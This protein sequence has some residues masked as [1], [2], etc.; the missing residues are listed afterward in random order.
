M[1]AIVFDRSDVPTE[2]LELREVE[3]PRPGA[4]EVLVKMLNAPI[5]PGDLLFIQSLYPDP[6][7]PSLPGQVAGNSG[8]GVVVEKGPG[9]SLA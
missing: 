9:T 7:K 4:G 2:V 5:N 6:K 8:T 1:K 3:R